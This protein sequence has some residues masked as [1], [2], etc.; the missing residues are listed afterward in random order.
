MGSAGGGG[1]GYV[2]ILIEAGGFDFEGE[3][4]VCSQPEPALDPPL[5]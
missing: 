1:D 4:V 2:D 3:G 5:T